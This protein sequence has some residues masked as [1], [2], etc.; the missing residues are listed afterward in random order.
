MWEPSTRST[1]RGRAAR[2]CRCP[3]HPAELFAGVETGL[4]PV[5]FV[6]EGAVIADLVARSTEDVSGD[7]SATQ[8]TE[9]W[10]WALSTRLGVAVP[11]THRARVSFSV[12]A[13]FLLNRFDHVVE[14]G[15]SETAAVAS[16][17]LARP[18]IELGVLVGL[19]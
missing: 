2:N 19:W 14:R 4:L 15:N 9:R 16:P 11:V 10:S 1:A 18:R 8:D 13:E 12:G 17:M 3:R 6:A 7:L 5:L